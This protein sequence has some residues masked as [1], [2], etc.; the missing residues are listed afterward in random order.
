MNVEETL[1]EMEGQVLIHYK[2]SEGLLKLALSEIDFE[3]FVERYDL[4]SQKG[5]AVI[6]PYG[7]GSQQFSGVKRVERI[8]VESGVE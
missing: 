8:I 7:A 6:V 2:P 4:P 5:T 1:L 3:T